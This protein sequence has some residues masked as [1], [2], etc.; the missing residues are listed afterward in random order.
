[1]SGVDEP[2]RAPR[3]LYTFNSRSA[4]Q[5]YAKGCDADIGGTSTVNLTL[6]ESEPQPTG[7]FWGDMRLAMRPELQGRIRGGYSGFR[8]TVLVFFLSFVRL[9]IVHHIL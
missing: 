8:S 2:T 9:L 7:K 6:D 1:M 5:N 3:T 4:L